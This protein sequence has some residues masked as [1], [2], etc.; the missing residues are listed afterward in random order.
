MRTFAVALTFAAVLVAQPQKSILG[1]VTEFRMSSLEFGL[2]PDNGAP[3]YFKVSPDTEVVQVEPG[4]RDLAKA[5]KV[6][7]TDLSLDDRVMVTFVPGMPEARR[8]VLISAT[9]ISKRNEAERVDWNKRGVSGTVAAVHSEEIT[10][11]PGSLEGPREI[12]VILTSKTKVR[13]YAPDSVKFADAQ[14]STIAEIAVGDQVRTRGNRSDDGARLT[15]EDVVYGTF[16]SAIGAITAIDAEA[17]KI[18]IA[19]L[20][21]KKPMTIRV[22]AGTQLKEMPDFR[23]LFKNGAPAAGH[24]APSAGSSPVTQAVSDP[25]KL[26]VAKL[27]EMLPLTKFEALKAGVAVMVTSTQGA[28]SDQ[29]TATRI[30]SNVNFLI[31]TAQAAAAQRGM[32]TMDAIAGMHGGAL[33]GS[34]GLSLPGIVP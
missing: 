30:I 12:T 32:T 28:S 21:T 2:Q 3:T 19:D 25:Q 22:T 29:V 23:G 7:L 13:R 6:R 1:T 31:E 34:G 4:E 33:G 27:I 26:D 5:K 17:H 15:A 24:G 16:R 8:I 11:R 10:L 14:W 18:T 20:V 9:D